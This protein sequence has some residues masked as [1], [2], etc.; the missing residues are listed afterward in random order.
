MH[1]T[2]CEVDFDFDHTLVS[3][4][5]RT[6]LMYTQI[7]VIN[8][9]T[10]SIE[11]ASAPLKLLGHIT[12]CRTLMTGTPPERFVA[13]MERRD[14]G[15][16][17]WPFLLGEDPFP[18]RDFAVARW[19]AEPADVREISVH[20]KLHT[21]ICQMKNDIEKAI[22][23]NHILPHRSSMHLRLDAEECYVLRDAVS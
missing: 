14:E 19:A 10:G 6:P 8:V 1:V 18:A 11:L 22:G 21:W 15:A 3:T 2:S 16:L 23:E 5:D 9:V 13:C 4:D 12:V 20:S 17:R 7:K